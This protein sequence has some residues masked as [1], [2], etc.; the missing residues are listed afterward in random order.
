MLG[1]EVTR[2]SQMSAS[3][4]CSERDAT[5]AILSPYSEHLWERKDGKKGDVHA[6]AYTDL[7]AVSTHLGTFSLFAS[8]SEAAGVKR[9]ILRKSLQEGLFSPPVIFCPQQ[10]VYKEGI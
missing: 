3:T 1:N 9:M 6:I 2:C 5:C 10:M 7:L 4:S 8:S